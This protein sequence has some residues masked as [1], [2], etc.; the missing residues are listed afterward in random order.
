VQPLNKNDGKTEGKASYLGRRLLDPQKNC[1]R[2]QKKNG[3][4]R[5][6]EKAKYVI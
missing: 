5:R 3:A 2:E 6:N 4:A 1:Q